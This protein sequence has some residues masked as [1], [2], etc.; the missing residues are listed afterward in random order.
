MD[1]QLHG[2]VA[3]VAAASQGIGR[4][5]ALGL[6][7]EGA[8]VSI[9]AR[10]LEALERTAEV[11]RRETGAQ[12]LAMR[13][14]V[15]RA[16]DIQAWVDA[17]IGRF[18]G[19]DILVT[20]AGGPPLGGWDDF[21]DDEAWVRAFELNLLSTIR[22]VRAVVPSMR[23]RGGG[24]ILNIQST[25]VKAPIPGLILSNSIRP[26]VVGLAKSLSRELAKDNILVNT[27][28]PGRIFADRQ[29]RGIAERAAKLGISE[30]AMAAER[31]KDIPLQ[32]FGTPEEVANMVVFLAS[33]R[34]SYITGSTIAVD[35]G[36]LQSLW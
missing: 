25:S 22:M 30:E 28:A 14:D 19:V 26:G 24:R 9:C 6:A 29:R 23:Q 16:D 5:C 15:T 31:A 17:T 2:K 1:L 35:G 12:V 36:L 18:G 32:R 34:A 33:P 20:N 21:P 10:G 4:A 11:I 27:I 3:M 7:R 8:H 13:A